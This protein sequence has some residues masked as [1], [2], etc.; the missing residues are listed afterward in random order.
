MQPGSVQ[1]VSMAGEDWDFDTDEEAAPGPTGKGKSRGTGQAAAKAKGKAKA[2]A[3][4][5]KAKDTAEVEPCFALTCEEPRKAHAIFCR[6]HENLHVAFTRRAK[7]PE[8]QQTAGKITTDPLKADTALGAFEKSKAEF[9]MRVQCDWE[10]MKEAFINSWVFTQRNREVLV[11]GIDFI[12]MKQSRMGS[13]AE[14]A[15]LWETVKQ[16]PGKAGYEFEGEGD[17]LKVWLQ[18][19]PERMKDH[20]KEI[21]MMFERATKAKKGDPSGDVSNQLSFTNDWSASFS[22]CFFT[23]II[24][25]RRPAGAMADSTGGAFSSAEAGASAADG[26]A[27]NDGGVPPPWPPAPAIGLSPPQP[28]NKKQKRVDVSLVAPQTFKKLTDTDIPNQENALN[29]LKTSMKAVF[30]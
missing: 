13:K 19:N 14:A 21:M 17:D 16:D 24:P 18:Q 3:R 29:D 23:G 22:H 7:T 1:L 28:G 12:L 9:G 27:D 5:R 10:T 15:A 11:D 8:E 25:K 30:L 20:K 4:G 6:R 2:Q 26:S